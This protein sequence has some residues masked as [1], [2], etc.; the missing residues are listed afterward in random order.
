MKKNSDDG[1]FLVAYRQLK[2]CDLYHRG[3]SQH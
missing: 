3:I 1:V 2:Y